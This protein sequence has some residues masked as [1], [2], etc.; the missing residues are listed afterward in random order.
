MNF[1][2]LLL[3]LGYLCFC[4][5]ENPNDGSDWDARLPE[6][7]ERYA[8]QSNCTDYDIKQD[9][10]CISF[11]YYSIAD[12]CIVCCSGIPCCS[13]DDC[14][15]CWNEQRTLIII[16]QIGISILFVFGLIGLIIVYCKICNRTRWQTRADRRRRRVLLHEH[17][18]LTQCSIIEG[19]QDRPPS[20]NEILHNAGS[21]PNYTSSLFP[22]NTAPPLY[23]SPYNG[24]STQEA[25]P[26]YPGTPKP[27]EKSDRPPSSS[28]VTQHM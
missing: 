17:R 9:P 5:A 13:C 3:L 7:S 1:H 20:Y 14:T 6:I 25:P 22:P 28:P 26:S 24:M 10:S 8:V 16:T 19:L 11:I 27:Q 21:P 2:L 23:T 15:I 12:R 18:D 4:V